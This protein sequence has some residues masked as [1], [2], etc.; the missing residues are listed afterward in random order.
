[1]DALLE[2]C[3]ENV[4]WFPFPGWPD[5]EEPRRGHAGVRELMAV[6]ID[7]FDGYEVHIHEIRD[8]DDRVLV[9]GEMTGQAKGTGV[10]IR[11]PLGWV[12]SDFRQG[13]IGEVH[14]FLTWDE[15]LKAAGL[16]E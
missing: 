16:R 2:F 15:T 4:V 6:W 13:Q 8:L 5:G 9:H 10:P 14:F 1:L 7:Y 12:A 11:Q 3:P